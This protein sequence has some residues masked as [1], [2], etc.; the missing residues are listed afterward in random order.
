MPVAAPVKKT[1]GASSRTNNIA[2]VV[3]LALFGVVFNA[4]QVRLVLMVVVAVT[5]LSSAVQAQESTCTEYGVGNN[6]GNPIRWYF[7]VNDGE[8]GQVNEI[9]GTNFD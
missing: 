4:R 3:A 1:S 8:G 9:S 2:A 7:G 6:T 5:V